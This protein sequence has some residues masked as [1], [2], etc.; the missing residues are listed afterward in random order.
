MARLV[1]S[2]L[3]SPEETPVATTVFAMDTMVYKFCCSTLIKICL[4]AEVLLREERTLNILEPLDYSYVQELLYI[5][6]YSNYLS[7]YSTT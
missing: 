3:T 7:M 6:N 4:Y 1:Q 2:A 5:R